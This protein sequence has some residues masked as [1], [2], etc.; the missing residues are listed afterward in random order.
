MKLT[1][2][3]RGVDDGDIRE[4]LDPEGRTSSTKSAHMMIEDSVMEA[5]TIHGRR[6]G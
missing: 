2:I 3:I 6:N 1:P 4:Q 5:D